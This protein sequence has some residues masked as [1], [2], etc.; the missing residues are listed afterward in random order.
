MPHVNKNDN[1]T[2]NPNLRVQSMC[3]NCDAS[4]VLS[5]SNALK[6]A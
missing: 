6:L 2:A 4:L 5:D 1:K 3:I